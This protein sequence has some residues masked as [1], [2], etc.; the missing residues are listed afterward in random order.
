MSLRTRMVLTIATPIALLLSALIYLQVWNSIQYARKQAFSKAEETAYRYGNEVGGH[1]TEALLGARFLSQTFEGMKQAWVDD[2]SLYNSVLSQLLKANTNYYAVWTCWEADALDGKDKEFAKK[3]GH[4]D[5][6]RF[7]PLWYRGKDD[8]QLD[9]LN[10]YKEAGQANYY[11]AAKTAGQERMLEPHRMKFGGR[12]V[13]VVTLAAPV[14]Y[15]GVVVGVVG[16]QLPAEQIQ[17]LVEG[18][19]PYETGF[20]T[21][22]SDTGNYVA[23]VDRS[24]IGKA[25]ETGTPLQAILS[26]ARQGRAFTQTVK[27]SGDQTEMFEVFVPVQVGHSETSWLLTVS[28]PVDR[29]LAEARRQMFVSIGL[30]AGALVLM[31]AVVMWLAQTIAGPLREAMRFV[32]QVAKERLEAHLEVRSTDEVGQITNALNQ[33]VTRWRKIVGVL[34]QVARGDLRTGIEPSA[35][36]QLGPISSTVNQMVTGLRRTVSAIGHS[37]LDLSQAS[38]DLSAASAQVRSSAEETTAQSNVAAVAAEQVGESIRSVAGAAGEVSA[39]THEIARN[40]AQ[41]AEVSTNAAALAARTKQTVAKLSQSSV[42]IGK[43]VAII[44]SIADQT[45]LL[46]LNAT[47]EA[48][49]AGAAGKGFAVVATEI[50]ELARQT[51]D[52]TEEITGK[53]VTTQSDAKAAV[54]AVQEIA[55]IIDQINAFQ[56]TIAHAVEEQDATTKRISHNAAEAAEGAVKIVGNVSGVAEAV[57]ITSDGATCAANAAAELARLAGQLNGLVDEFKLDVANVESE[58]RSWRADRA[59][60]P[61]GRASGFETALGRNRRAEFSP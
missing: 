22:I 23:H 28:V 19:R 46:A 49:R 8:I 25:V 50:K 56:M 58:G 33:L 52:A 40:A 41:A 1:L 53:I 59:A 39:T 32:E 34:E 60:G 18:I 57:K 35:G 44:T 6:G 30:G 54:T 37:S 16:V 13:L 5:T 15:N 51:S 11:Q 61:D 48:A 2:R 3:S 14:R 9:K 31:V 29:I 36:Q 45:K 21:F 10:G 7:I 47:I 26:G 43:V 12:E 55:T 24:R 27:A 17:C 42:E 38:R 20:A 4:D